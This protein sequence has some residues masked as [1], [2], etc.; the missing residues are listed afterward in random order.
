MVGAVFLVSTVAA[1][2]NELAPVFLQVESVG[3]AQLETT[4]ALILA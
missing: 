4:V 2:E 1:S 3:L